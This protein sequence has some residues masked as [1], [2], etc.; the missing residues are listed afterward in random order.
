MTG[1]E[2]SWREPEEE[3]AGEGSA[4]GVSWVT[5]GKGVERVLTHMPSRICFE[6]AD[7][8][9]E[10]VSDIDPRPFTCLCH[11]SIV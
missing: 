10:E 6:R 1:E 7:M 9:D 8:P 11:W 2:E 4:R 3:T 5:V